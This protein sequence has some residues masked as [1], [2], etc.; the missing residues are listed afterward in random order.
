MKPIIDSNRLFLAMP[1]LFKIYNKDKSF[2]AYDDREKD[3]IIKNE[4]KSISF[5]VTRFKGLG[6]MPANQL[7]DTTMSIEKRKLI[8]IKS[9]TEKKEI[10]NTDKLFEIL[11]GKKAEFRFKFIKENANFIK[12]IDT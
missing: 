10:K 4:F 7:K 2:Y 1:P 5:Y 6:E 8:N 9:Y 11:M 12:Q 3:K